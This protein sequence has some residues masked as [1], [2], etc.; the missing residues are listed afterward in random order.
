MVPAFFSL[1]ATATIAGCVCHGDCSFLD[2]GY[3][4]GCTA[5]ILFREA[6][7][8]TVTKSETV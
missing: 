5:S 4:D 6:G 2:G 1:L 7:T 8:T 3:I